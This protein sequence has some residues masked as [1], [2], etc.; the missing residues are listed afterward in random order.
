VIA[1]STAFPEDKASLLR[2]VPAGHSVELL[3]LDERH[4]LDPNFFANPLSFPRVDGGVGKPEGW[5]KEYLKLLGAALS[6]SG[7]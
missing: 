4:L 2:E 1:S 5:E 3:W 6:D 7:A